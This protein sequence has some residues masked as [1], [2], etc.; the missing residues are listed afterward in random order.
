MEIKEFNLKAN[1][2]RLLKENGIISKEEFLEMRKK[3]INDIYII[4]EKNI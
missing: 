2:L 4:E 3:L 1:K